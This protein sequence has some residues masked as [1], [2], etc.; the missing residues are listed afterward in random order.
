MFSHGV[1]W[2]CW[3]R[4]REGK[5]AR[6]CVA[7]LGAAKRKT[8]QELIWEDRE[9]GICSRVALDATLQ[10]LEERKLSVF[11]I[12]ILTRSFDYS[13]G[14]IVAGLSSRNRIVTAWTKR[15]R[16]W[17]PRVIHAEWRIVLTIRQ[18]SMRVPLRSVGEVGSGCDKMLGR[19]R[20]RDRENTWKSQIIISW[21]GNI[22]SH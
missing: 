20:K 4:G 22:H 16:H 12:L 5:S 2:R 11:S 3:C 18:S 6:A 14:G 15:R 7:G 13:R 1:W 21:V 8:A 17:W 19:G 9:L 10:I